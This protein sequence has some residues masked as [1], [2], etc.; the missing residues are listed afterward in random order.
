MAVDITPEIQAAFERFWAAYPRRPGDARHMA[1]VN[2]AK[3]M[4]AGESAE[5]LIASAG[6]YAKHIAD[7]AT[8]PIFIQ[9]AKTWLNQRRFEDFPASAPS[10]PSPEGPVGD[11]ALEFLRPIAGAADFGSWISPLRVETR[12][13]DVAVIAPRQFALD[14]VRRTWGREIVA[15]LGPVNWIVERS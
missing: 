11:P 4:K 3:L 15:V 7:R 6:A 1:L 9:Q 14:H 8:D 10:A 5:A 13:K 12:G 2:F